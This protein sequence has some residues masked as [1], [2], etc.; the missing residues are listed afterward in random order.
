MERPRPPAPT[1]SVKVREDVGVDRAAE[2]AVL[3]EDVF[4]FTA[5]DGSQDLVCPGGDRHVTAVKPQ[6]I[7][8]PLLSE[9]ELA[10]CQPRRAWGARPQRLQVERPADKGSEPQMLLVEQ[11]QEFVEAPKVRRNR[12]HVSV[13]VVRVDVDGSAVE[14]GGRGDLRDFSR[15]HKLRRRELVE[16]VRQRIFL[17]DDPAEEQ[18]KQ[19]DV[20]GIVVIEEIR[21]TCGGDGV[22]R[23]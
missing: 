13:L 4:L 22:G 21:R 14:L 10:D 16:Q 5:D 8:V 11:G 19:L 17:T 1:T 9:E 23:C 20:E 7:G 15:Q 2:R 3:G 6:L 12:C 18:E